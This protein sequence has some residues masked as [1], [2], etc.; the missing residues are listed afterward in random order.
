MNYTFRW[1]QRLWPSKTVFKKV[2][3]LH[4]TKVYIVW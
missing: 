4:R 1:L 2:S 3:M